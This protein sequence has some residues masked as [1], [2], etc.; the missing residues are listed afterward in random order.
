MTIE[1]IMPGL[2]ATGEKL[3]PD[4][5]SID[6]E[7]LLRKLPGRTFRSPH[8]YPVELVRAA[9]V[10]SASRVEVR[11]S[12]QSAV[13]TDDGPGLDD[14]TLASLASV[15]DPALPPQKRQEALASF[16]NESG[17]GII[18]A[19]APSPSEVVIETGGAAGGARRLVLRR[20]RSPVTQDMEKQS[21]TRIVISR[22]EG[23]PGK[24]K[25]AVGD[26][27]RFA[28]AEI[29]VNGRLISRLRGREDQI[30]SE[31]LAPWEACSGGWVWIP[32]EGDT[33]RV[34]LLD[35][36]VRW[37][38]SVYPPDQG[39]VY[40][41]SVE[42]GG[43][44]PVGCTRHIRE[45]AL[46]LY[47]RMAAEYPG[48]G[49]GGAQRVEELL[50]LHYRHTSD[51]SVVESFAP[52][53]VLPG[54]RRMSLAEI[55]D[56]AKEGPLYAI[57]INEN[58]D[59]YDTKSLTVLHLTPNQ[60]EFLVEHAGVRLSAPLPSP[61]S[62]PWH[63]RL[64]RR[65]GSAVSN[66]AARAAFGMLRPVPEGSLLQDEKLLVE[67]VSAELAAKRFRLPGAGDDAAAKVVMSDGWGR[68][69]GR[70]LTRGGRK[71]LALS[72]RSRRVREAAS[73]LMKDARNIT[74]VLPMLTGGHDGWR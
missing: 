11:L 61:R 42:C 22:K 71:V 8:H 50:F 31:K 39:M 21:G 25:E 18:A 28:E 35:R 10:R 16:E 56:R 2:E 17:I 52:F 65:V 34:W 26:Y 15:F 7:A 36:G 48:Q 69:P 58:K 13:I 59:D 23:D 29:L 24:E 67:L 19:F 41:A 53:R 33:C 45:V 73:A 47:R 64:L 44:R 68:T 57:R 70:I 6:I 72:R 46:E 12:R 66:V 63:V 37:H 32:G 60:W 55:R 9:L 30:A 62:E 43:K 49:R 20:G 51:A 14:V 1:K 38:L 74:L 54:R 4:F 3:D 5:L 27:C 40:E